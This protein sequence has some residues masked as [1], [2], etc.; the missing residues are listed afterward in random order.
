MVI[1]GSDV[2]DN[3]AKHIERCAHADGLLDFHVG[4]NLI[5]R[6]MSGAFNH[7]LNVFFPSAF[8]QFAQT[9]QFFNLTYI[10]AVCQTAGTAGIAKGNGNIIFPADFQNFIEVFIKGVF[11]ASHTHPS[12]NKRAATRNDVHFS[13]MLFD[14]FNG[15]PCDAAVECDEVN[16]VFCVEANHINKIFGSQGSQ[17][18]LIM[19]DTVIYRN[20]ADHGRTFTG[21][22]SAEGL[23]I[24]M[25]G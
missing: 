9:Y 6:H 25:G 20:G 10:A 21:K 15:F 8:G 24:A 5:H 18:S 1:T 2:C 23:S 7:N 22:F 14:L 12:E 11:F 17:I 19:D 3:R 4:S 13:F 16:A